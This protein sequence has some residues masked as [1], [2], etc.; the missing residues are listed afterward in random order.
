MRP[1]SSSR[2]EAI[3]LGLGVVIFALII[4]WQTTR[5]SSAAVYATV[6]PAIIPWLVSA[7]LAALG[8]AI[9]IAGLTDRWRGEAA[10]GALDH[11][12]LAW[13][14]AGLALNIALIDRAGFII[15]STILFV[16]AARAF[17]SARYLRNAALGFAIALLCYIGFDRVLGYEIGSGLI[18]QFL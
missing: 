10:P 4:A 5:I 1:D 6:G 16:C 14:L 3:A 17:G 11:V 18:E 15:A 2:R 12:A 8:V 7:A 9:I 13:L